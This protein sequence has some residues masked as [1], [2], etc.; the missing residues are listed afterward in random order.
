MGVGLGV[1]GGMQR[2]LSYMLMYILKNK[3]KHR[4]ARRLRQHGH[5]AQ[6]REC[7]GWYRRFWLR[8]IPDRCQL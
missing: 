6:R 2:T 3:K 5:I 7:S 8:L 4:S 1:G